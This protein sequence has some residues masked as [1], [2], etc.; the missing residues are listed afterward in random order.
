MVFQLSIGWNIIQ[1]RESTSVSTRVSVLFENK[2]RCPCNPIQREFV[3]DLGNYT[4]WKEG[5]P[6]N[7]YFATIRQVKHQNV[8]ENFVINFFFQ[9]DG[10][11]S[12]GIGKALLKFICIKPPS[13]ATISLVGTGFGTDLTSGD[14]IGEIVDSVTNAG[15]LMTTS[16]ATDVQIAGKI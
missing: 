2:G 12:S 13:N 8:I 16:V 7:N 9:K 10:L 6:G 15:S 11:W 4:N 1:G 14:I 3:E 5:H